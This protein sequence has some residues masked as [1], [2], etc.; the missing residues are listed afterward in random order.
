MNPNL[1][2]E[3]VAKAKKVVCAEFPEMVGAEPAISEKSVQGKGSRG[4]KSVFVL[5]FQKNIP[6]QGGGHLARVVRVTMGQTGEVIKL[7]SSK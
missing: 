2:P 4:G 7:S 5:T 1:A 3:H 6:L